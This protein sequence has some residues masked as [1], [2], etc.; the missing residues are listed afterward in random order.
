MTW[1]SEICITDDA[2]TVIMS[3]FSEFKIIGFGWLKHTKE[4]QAQSV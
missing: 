4:L 1:M 3:A 2:I